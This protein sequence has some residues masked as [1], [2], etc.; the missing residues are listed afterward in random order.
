[1]D[2][3][4]ILFN[5]RQSQTYRVE[6]IGMQGNTAVLYLSLAQIYNDIRLLNFA[7]ALGLQA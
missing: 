4:D 1:M 6:V 5:K 7:E 2:V 3:D